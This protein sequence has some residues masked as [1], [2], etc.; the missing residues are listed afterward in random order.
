MKTTN[1]RS[2]SK[3]LMDDLEPIQDWEDE[4]GYIYPEVHSMNDLEAAKVDL[5]LKALLE[6]LLNQPEI[7][8]LT[9][10]EGS[11]NGY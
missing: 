7:V 10:Q 11:D 9:P 8:G 4:G 6:V 3:N 1:K 5:E 2:V